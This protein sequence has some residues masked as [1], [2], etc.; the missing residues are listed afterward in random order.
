[1]GYRIADPSPTISLTR[2]SAQRFS[3]GQQVSQY[4]AGS[5]PLPP[6]PGVICRSGLGPK[7]RL[8]ERSADS[9]NAS[10]G[11]AGQAA[12]LG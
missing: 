5:R 1:M 10:I 6:A 12:S 11:E 7:E 9:R 4:A 3:V 2:H 8:D